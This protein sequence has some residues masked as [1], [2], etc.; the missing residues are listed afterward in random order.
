MHAIHVKFFE[1]EKE[2]YVY[3]III[4]IPILKFEKESLE[5]FSF[6]SLPYI[7]TKKCAYYR[8]FLLL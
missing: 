4:Y 3:K 8:A 6:C 1:G 7:I 5:T 2:T